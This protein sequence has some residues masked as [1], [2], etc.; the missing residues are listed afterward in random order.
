MQL[1]LSR[2]SGHT[3]HPW[4]FPDQ[5]EVNLGALHAADTQLLTTKW[6]RMNKWKE[7]RKGRAMCTWYPSSTNRAKA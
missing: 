1:A 7:G 2:P 4:V 3:E 6:D 5:E